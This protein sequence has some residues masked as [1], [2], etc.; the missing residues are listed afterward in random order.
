MNYEL[1]DELLEHMAAQFSK[2]AIGYDFK[3]SEVKKIQGN[4]ENAK[5][6]EMKERKKEAKATKENCTE[7]GKGKTDGGSN[8]KKK[9]PEKKQQGKP[10]KGGPKTPGTGT[11]RE[12]KKQ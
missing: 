6:N 1:P 4:V 10:Q 8:A 7:K 12:K 3:E 2:H 11:K 5:K 9:H